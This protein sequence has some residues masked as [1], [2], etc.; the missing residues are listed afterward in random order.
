MFKNKPSLYKTSNKEKIGELDAIRA[1]NDKISLMLYGTPEINK[2]SSNAEFREVTPK[3]TT[4]NKL[5]DAMEWQDKN[6][7]LKN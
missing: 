5:A 6:C 1:F 7:I 3:V 4:Q 2:Y